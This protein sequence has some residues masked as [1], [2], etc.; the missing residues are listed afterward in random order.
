M[1]GGMLRRIA[2]IT[3]ALGSGVVGCTDAE[4][5]PLA[6]SPLVETA[7]VAAAPL[8]PLAAVE[9]VS[10]GLGAD[11][12]TLS[13]PK[14]PRPRYAAATIERSL[15]YSLVKATDDEQG[16]A[17]AQ[18]VKR[19]LVWWLDVRRELHPGDR[20]HVVYEAREGAEPLLHALWFTG[21]KFGRTKSVVR[22]QAE[23]SAFA[24]YYEDD[25]Q[26]VELRLVHSPMADYEQVT[27]LLSD[28][29]GHKGVDFKA[30]SGTTILAPFEGKVVRRNWATRRNGNC[31]ELE[32]SKTGHRVY[33]LHLNSIAADMRP[34]AHVKRGQSIARSGNT[35]R[36]TAP[37]LHYQVE[38]RG[39][40][41]DPFRHYPTKRARLSES[42]TEKV[43]AALARWAELKTEST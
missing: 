28:G 32:E 42:E 9:P 36:S 12:P 6:P 23:G 25:G 29:R 19:M 38:R 30:P 41:I 4:A 35:G 7:S 5:L 43:R 2:A 24:R 27:S 26:E 14:S 8:A 34:G 10:P 16:P 1:R 37:H 22:Y 40:A 33:F 11:A 3:V 15:E 39:R 31:L 21:Q 20:V 13:G 17:L 18:V